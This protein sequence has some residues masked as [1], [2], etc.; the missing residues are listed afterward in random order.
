[1]R[2]FAGLTLLAALLNLMLAPSNIS[3]QA[4]AAPDSS[5]FGPGSV[6]ELPIVCNASDY[7]YNASM[8][9]ELPNQFSFHV[10]ANILEH[11]RTLIVH[12]AYDG[13]N[14]RER[15]NILIND[16]QVHFV[17][18][19][20]NN[21]LF[22]FPDIFNNTD[23]R[24]FPL[25]SSRFVLAL[26]LVI[27]G[28]NGSVQIASPRHFIEN[29]NDDTPVRMVGPANIRG[30][31]TMQ[32]QACF[33]TDNRSYV[34]DYY[35][36]TDAWDYATMANPSNMVLTQIKIN[37]YAFG[38][39]RGRQG[40]NPAMVRQFNHIYTITGYHSGPSSVPSRMFSIPNGLACAGRKAGIPVPII[41][42]FFSMSAEQV[43]TTSDQS[44]PNRVSTI[45][46]SSNRTCF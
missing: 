25:D 9:P 30:I 29:I 5:G 13:V 39:Q 40:N 45:R 15:L 6:E 23:C 35:F 36:T 44:I 34:A 31:P 21:E 27:I 43:I 24:V 11:N 38:R 3:A 7:P 1:M 4:T 26:G 2:T 28:S 16:T 41:P 37:G 22:M 20:S 17:I 46:V 42:D 12:Q 32:Y 8:L 10:E 14:N 19:A 33:N 18:D